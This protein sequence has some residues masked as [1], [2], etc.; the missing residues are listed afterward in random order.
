MTYPFALDDQIIKAARN[1]ALFALNLSGG[2]DST[3]S[4]HA[5]SAILDELGHDRSRRIL[6]HADLGRA[7][8]K[9]TPATVERQAE[10]IG[11]PL[12][13]TRRQAGDMVAR[14]EQRFDQGLEL[15]SKLKLAKLRGPW[16]TSGSRYCTAELKRDVLH[17]Y[18][19]STYPGETI[20]SVLGI[21]HAESPGRSKT[22]ISKVD[23][24]LARA[25]GTNGILWHPSIHIPTPAVYDYHR[26]HGLE[27]HEAYE[28]YG[29]SRLSCAFCVLASKGDITISAN[30]PDNLDLYHYLVDLELRT[31][32]SFQ[33]GGWLC[34][35]S[36]DNLTPELR[37][38]V[39]LTKAY[40]AE[41]RNIEGRISKE[42]LEGGSKVN[43]PLTKATLADAE[44]I[45]EA[46][47]LNALW[48]GRDLPFLT[49]EEVLHQ[50]D[51]MAAASSVI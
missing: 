39:P 9:S 50:L 31:G 44:A 2:K 27:L 30:V 10:Q 21:R 16:P 46:R 13:I 48:I 11:L 29:A 17:R 45:A 8:W 26:E 40:A 3:M 12:A 38:R 7:E 51:V 25:N 4:A 47:R 15:Y 37:A 32:F 35:V 5:A 1:N 34:D 24:K 19:A 33:Q 41:R 14:F 6:L 22:P 43:W 42:F 18:L 23:T 49:T 20:V 28:V 36:P